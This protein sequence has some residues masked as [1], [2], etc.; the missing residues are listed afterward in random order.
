MH[1]ACQC[2]EFLR[3]FR[4]SR[5]RQAR[6]TTVEGDRH[7]RDIQ[8]K[9]FLQP[10]AV[11]GLF[12]W[13]SCHPYVPYHCPNN[14]HNNINYPRPT[15]YDSTFSLPLSHSMMMSSSRLRCFLMPSRR[16]FSSTRPFRSTTFSGP[17]PP[18]LPEAEQK[19]Y[20]NL[21]RSSRGA[22]STPNPNSSLEQEST[23]QESQP[24][25]KGPQIDPSSHGE[26]QR[27]SGE[28]GS[29]A[30]N[31]SKVRA[32]GEGDELHPDVRR[33]AQPEFEGEINPKTGEVGGPKNEPLRWGGKADW[34]Y[35]GRVTDF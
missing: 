17:T 32:T 19:T 23:S 18:R 11:Q 5:K 33:G 13:C 3:E 8:A 30:G 15:F 26:V 10:Y 20:E 29:V 34:S 21:Q 6:V 12:I 28:E 14:C 24:Q 9:E 25:R 4:F 35:N 16:M 2:G 1:V 7:D 27:V 22:F 31:N